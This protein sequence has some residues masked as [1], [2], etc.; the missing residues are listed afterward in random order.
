MGVGAVDR[1]GGACEEGVE[2]RFDDRVGGGNRGGEDLPMLLLLLAPHGLLL[3]LLLLVVVEGLEAETA[4][5]SSKG[6]CLCGGVE[7]G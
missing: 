6:D 4:V 1:W 2:V 5:A 7:G 3:L